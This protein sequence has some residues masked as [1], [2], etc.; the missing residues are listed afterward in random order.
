MKFRSSFIIICSLLFATGV[1]AQ[2]KIY[3]HD[4][5]VIN[6]TVKEVGVKNISYKKAD[7]TDGPTYTIPKA[8]VDKIEYKNGSTDDFEEAN[9]IQAAV[10]HHRHHGAGAEGDGKHYGANIISVIPFTMIGD[11]IQSGPGLGISYER[12]LD[13]K[14]MISFYLPLAVNFVTTTYYG[15][16]YSSYTTNN[17]SSNFYAMPGVK[18]YPTGSNGICKY[19]LGTSLFISDG[20]KYTTDSYGYQIKQTYGTF[21]IIINN[22]L[23]VCANSHIY[24]NIEGGL[25]M[26]YTGWGGNANKFGGFLGQFSMRVG[27]RF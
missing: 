10:P 26:S 4:G 5:D 17:T 23:N 24:F 19:A 25:G 3:T 2:D 16:P 14:G 13:K 9:N 1:Y 21:G 15:T 7:N 20:T 27:Y 22:S 18:I 11:N 8:Q 12:M 6:G